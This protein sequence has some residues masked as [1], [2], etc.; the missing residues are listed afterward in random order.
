[1][2]PFAVRFLL[3]AA[4]LVSAGRPLAGQA[5]VERDSAGIR[6]IENPSRATAP[7]V[8]RLGDR[9]LDLG[10]PAG[11]PDDEFNQGFGLGSLRLTDGT[12]AV[13]DVVRLQF[14]DAQGRRIGKVGRSGAGPSE[15]VSAYPSEFCRTRGDTLVVGDYRNGRFAVVHGQRVVTTTRYTQ[16]FGGA[17]PGCFDDGTVLMKGGLPDFRTPTYVVRLNR[18]R[19]DGTL[20]NGLG[21]FVFRSPSDVAHSVHPIV[22]PWGQRVYLGDGATSEIRIHRS[23]GRLTHIIRTADPPQRITAEDVERELRGSPPAVRNQWRPDTYPTYQLFMVDP[24][25]RLWVRDFIPQPQRGGR[26]GWTAFD[27]NGR[28]IG[29]LEVPSMISSTGSLSAPFVIPPF[30]PRRDPYAPRRSF[31]P[32]VSVASVAGFGA[33]DVQIWWQDD[34]GFAHLSFYPIL[35]VER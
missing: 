31:P 20:V 21:D 35:R 18:L 33:N 30:T 23:D 4:V 16:Q 14:F 27:I 28:L 3:V 11:N 25:G 32:G 13:P 10:G 29:R 22:Q 19:L 17:L 6:I 1:M 7:V 2:T 5:P 9:T 12:I 8:F 24:E 34:D 15:F 26:I